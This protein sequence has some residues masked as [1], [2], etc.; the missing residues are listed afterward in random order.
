MSSRTNNKRV[1]PALSAVA[2]IITAVAVVA[3]GL[4]A[5]PPATAL[6]ARPQAVVLGVDEAT[7]VVIGPEVSIGEKFEVV[8]ETVET[9]THPRLM[10]PV[11]KRKAKVAKKTEPKPAV[12]RVKSHEGPAK[13]PAKKSSEK[14][15]KKASKKAKSSSGWKKA[16]A[17]WYGPGLYGNGMA[18]GGKLKKNSMVVAHRSLPFGTKIK[19]KYKGKTVTAVVKDRGPFIKGRIFDLGPGTAKALGFSGVGTIKYKIVR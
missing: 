16:K 18:G 8:T 2:A 1:H 15:S 17:S 3:T 12:S 5:F 13:R 4:T 14:A 6:A 19:I 9:T 7:A 10:L 11:K